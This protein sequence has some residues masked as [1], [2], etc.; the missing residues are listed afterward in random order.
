[1]VNESA[2][3]HYSKNPVAPSPPTDITKGTSFASFAMEPLEIFYS[4]HSTTMRISD[5][6]PEIDC[7]NQIRALPLNETA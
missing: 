6:R 3:G 7:R 1:V 2:A 4:V 5:K